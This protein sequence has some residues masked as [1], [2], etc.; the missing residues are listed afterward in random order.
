MAS[1]RLVNGAYVLN[2]YLPRIV[3]TQVEHHL[4]I[5]GAVVIEGPRACGKTRTGLHH[6][7]SHV[8]LDSEQSQA[9]ARISPDALLQGD[10]PR[11]L[12]EWQVLPSLW[13]SVRREVDFTTDKGL[14]LL[15][16][17][18]VPADDITRH[19]GAGR[20]M[21]IRQRTMTWAEK[22]TSTHNVQFEDL[23]TGKDIP[24]NLKTPTLDAVLDG[25]LLPGF[26]GMVGLSENDS[27]ELLSAYLH[28]IARV[29][30]PRLYE[31]RQEPVVLEHLIRALARSVS[32]EVSLETIRK[33]ISLVAP[34]VSRPTVSSLLQVLQRLFVLESVP[35]WSPKLRSRARLRTSAKY[36]LADPA[37]SAVALRA[38]R[39]QLSNDLETLGFIFESAVMH[40]LSVYAEALGG[41]LFHYRDSNGYEIDA[42]IEF[43]DGRWGAVEIKLGGGH[44]ERGAQSLRAAV[45]QLDSSVG[46]PSFMAVITGTG[47]A[48]PIG[49]AMQTFPLQALT[50]KSLS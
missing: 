23:I 28:E 38:G 10:K 15:T 6:S 46:K 43:P 3:D 12:D 34:E 11:L 30:I 44:I 41:R 47:V 4:R 8:F 7:A 49:D 29:D 35:A 32:A 13:N 2:D 36:H 14:F 5:A 25:I 26:P 22:G 20:F 19:S 33:D 27:H 31:T 45:S 1:M 37:L 42:I 18:S 21:R 9:L 50:M 17:S 48:A 16:G 24:V 39:A 40:D